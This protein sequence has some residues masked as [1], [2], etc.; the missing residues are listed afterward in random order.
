M[1]DKQIRQFNYM[2]EILK[3]IAKG[4]QTPNQIRKDC[5]KNLG[6][7]YE[8]ALEMAYENIRQEAWQ[9]L[10]G[11]REIKPKKSDGLPF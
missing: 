4:Y 2:R 8:E 7:D 5:H 11:V 10:V 1:T 3:L 9:A 6:L